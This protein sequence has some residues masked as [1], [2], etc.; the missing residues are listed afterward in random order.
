MKMA[1]AL[2]LRQ[3]A[4]GTS[5]NVEPIS[6]ADLPDGDVLISVLY[7][8]LNYKDALAV[9]GRGKIVRAEYPFVPGIDLVGRVERSDSKLFQEGDLVIATGWGLG[10]SRWGGYST[11]QRVESSNL[12]RLPRGMEPKTAMAIGTAGLTAMLAAM[13]L[14]EHGVDPDRGDVLVTGATGGVGSIAVAILA[15]RGYRVVA[16]TGSPDAHAYLEDLGASDIL[17]RSE[18]DKGPDR[19]MQ[20]AR[21]AGAVDV[22]GGATLASIIAALARHGSVAAC[23]LAGGA[24]LHTTVYPF[25]LRGVNLLGIDSNMC[26]T[27]RRIRAWQRLNDTL[28]PATIERMTSAVISLDDVPAYSERILDGKVRG[29]IVVDLSV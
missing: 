23:G 25:I 1:R 17:E 12:V 26:P 10:E 22:V 7:S 15:A 8:S 28:E 13:A 29:R 3:S 20:S 24:D 18:L 4:A 21:W 19:P 2:V 16:S 6:N 9:T 14:E 5:A 27:E 11:V